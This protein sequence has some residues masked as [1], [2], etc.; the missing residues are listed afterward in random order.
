MEAKIDTAAKH[1][2]AFGQAGPAMQTPMAITDRMH[3][4]LVTLADVLEGCT[5]G[6]PKEAELAALADAI[7]A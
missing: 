3:V 2:D 4:L 6:S 7:E 5:E 1:L